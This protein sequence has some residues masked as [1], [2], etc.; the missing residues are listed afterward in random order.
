LL[1]ERSEAQP[2]IALVKRNNYAARHPGPDDILLIVEVA[3]ATLEYEREVKLALYA[4]HAIAEVWLLDGN[5][6]E[7]TL[8]S[9]PAEGRYRLVRKPTRTEA[10][11]P[12][13]VP[14]VA[15]LW[16]ELVV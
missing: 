5:A 14:D 10:V 16:A 1:G 4:R 9:E 15:L 8:Y 13:L 7:L 2:D 12:T 6:G 11:S 3:D